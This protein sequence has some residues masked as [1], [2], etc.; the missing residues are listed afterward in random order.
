MQANRDG[1]Q[2]GAIPGPARAR[3]GSR[4]GQPACGRAPHASSSPRWL[5]LPSSGSSASSACSRSTARACRPPP[6]SRQIQFASESVVYDR[7]GTVELARFNGGENR[8]AGHLRADP[9]D[10]DRRRRRRSRTS[11]SGPT[12]ASTRLAS[13]PPPS[14]PLRGDD[15][16]AST[17]TQQLVRQR[18]LDP[19]L[20]QDPNR[21]IERKIKEIIQSVR[22]T[23]AYP[24]EA[25]KQQIITAYLNQNYYGNGSY[26]VLAAAQGY[27][28]VDRPQ[29]ADAGPGGAAG[30]PPAVAV[31][32]RPGAQR[33]RTAR[34]PAVRAPRHGTSRSSSGATT[35]STCSPRIRSRCV[36]TGN[37][38]TARQDFEAAKNEPIIL[39]P[40]DARA[41]A[42]VAG[43]ALRLGRA[44]RAGR[45][46]VRRRRD[47]PRAGA[48]R[49]QDHHHARLGRS[50]RSP[51]SGSTAGV[52]LPHAADPEAFA[53]QIGVPYETWMRKLEK[54][55]VNN[56]AMIAMDYQTGEIVAYVGSAG[57]YRDDM[58]SPAVPAAV[59]RPGR[60]L[61]PAGIGVQAVQL[62]HRHQRPAR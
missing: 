10:P 25:G 20:V 46:A 1:R 45:Q 4:R 59:R 48:R 54:L 18:L 27:F 28:G 61:A 33:G 44:R 52:V 47:V 21:L 38:Y 56:G 34:R 51:R 2:A 7:T 13:Y 19:D 40:Q 26:G 30:R 9:A 6:I 23:E 55:Q 5:S 35:S 16:G 60:R 22:V 57:Y 62:R 24:G 31:V 39:A 50:S 17:I 15:R 43:A 29:R 3:R 32:V 11:R 49:P 37:Q 41:A 36:L 58:S 42:A 53:A 8:A 14:T 12:P